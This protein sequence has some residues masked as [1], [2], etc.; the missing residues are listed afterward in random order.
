[1]FPEAAAQLW[2]VRN[3]MKDKDEIETGFARLSMMGYR[4]IQVSGLPSF[5][6]AWIYEVANKYNLNICCTHTSF[7]RII[8]EMEQVVKEHD[9]LH[10]DIIGI[11]I[12]PGK[13]PNTPEGFFEFAKVAE[14]TGK[15]LKEYGKRFTYHNH[16]FD[17]QKTDGKT[18]MDI[19]IENT[20]PEHLG[21][22]FDTY[23]GQAGGINPV[24]YIYKLKGRIDVCHWKDMNMD[25]WKPV[26]AEIGQG[27][28]NFTEILKACKE[29][30]VKYIAVEQDDCY[31]KDPFDCLE[32]SLNYIQKIIG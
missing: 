16:N 13:F 28:L 10:C 18:R 3:Q 14:E 6:P 27:N 30:G 7:D 9:I 19:L 2:T 20:R 26:F 22:I 5:D 4:N 32:T 15:K 11:G 25:G 24:E 23:W 8:N 12:I 31:G 17:F 21:I 29:T 1:M